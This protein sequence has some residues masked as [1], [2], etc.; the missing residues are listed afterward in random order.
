FNN[1]TR[2]VVADMDNDGKLDLVGVWPNGTLTA[3]LN[4]GTPGTPR[5]YTQVNIGTGFNGLT[6][7]VVQDRNGDGKDDLVGTWPNGIE[8]LYIN[9]GTPGRPAFSG[10]TN[11]GSGWDGIARIFVY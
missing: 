11:V 9:G 8:T 7:L 4:G 6:K 2:I 1:L 3:Y 5:F 10:Q